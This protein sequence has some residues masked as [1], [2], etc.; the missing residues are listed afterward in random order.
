MT[1]I[2]RLLSFALLACVL[3]A[4]NRQGPQQPV[5]VDNATAET[6]NPTGIGTVEVEPDAAF[7]GS[8]I[9]DRGD[10]LTPQH[11]FG[12]GATVYVSVP[13]KGRRLGSRVEAFWFHED[14]RSRKDEAKKIAGPFTAFEFQPTDAG[15]YNVEIDVNNRPIALVQFEIK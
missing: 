15:K 4:C 12:A 14:G 2:H 6:E 8:Q 10:L 11:D 9:D 13:S 7:V 1:P 3:A 5:A